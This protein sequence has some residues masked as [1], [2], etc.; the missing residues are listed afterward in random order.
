[1]RVV[2]H[3]GARRRYL[4]GA[5]ILTAWCATI[6][7]A[8]TIA[9]VV[10]DVHGNPLEG[11]QIKMTC[12]QVPEQ[13]AQMISDKDGAYRFI[14]LRPG[15]CDL[16]AERSGFRVSTPTVIT[17][18]SAS[19]SVVS[20]FTLS[21][22][23]Q[24]ENPTASQPKLKF[25]AAGIRGLI[26]PG[27]YSAAANAAAA[28]GVISGIA[29]IRR[30]ENA[31][32]SLV[33]KNLPCSLAP[34]L[35]EAV[36]EDPQ[37]ADANR[38]LGEFYLVHGSA[39]Q[40]IPYL[41]R[42]RQIDVDDSRTIR[43]L[44]E[45]LVTSGQF[46][47]AYEMLS[48]LPESQKDSNYHQ[49]L[50]RAEEGLGQYPQAAEEYRIATERDPNEENSF[51]IGYELILAGQPNAAAK[52]FNA[53]LARHPSS[54]TLLIGA[55]A[56]E[57][58]EGRGSEAVKLFL[59]AADLNP[60]DPRPYSFL[61]GVLAISGEQDEEVRT[62]LKRHL[63]FSSTDAEAYY[64]YALGLLHG[65]AKDGVIDNDRVVSLLKQAV[66]FN[67]TLTKAHFEL[68][69][70]YAHREDY[71]NA[72]REFE[73]AVRLAPDMKEAH[74]RLASAYKKIGRPEAAEREMKLFREARDSSKIVNGESGISIEQFISVVDRSGH[75]TTSETQCGQ[76]SIE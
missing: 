40:A 76:S 57:F 41:K 4:A 8:A 52:A 5:W 15:K 53:G 19:A 42:A 65:S 27:G 31:P 35:T 29:D 68:G 54:I 1:M 23:S 43:D 58:L 18:S 73:V 44:S 66:V 36:T 7:E 48:L 74:Y 49:H 25:E 45:A 26:D 12:E 13:T 51:G 11:A 46:D 75:A 59:Q 3:A 69:I 9:G 14:E 39:N 2:L 61:A 34:E 62:A 16:S 6:A 20:D 60:S 64:L 24:R 32:D 67:P 30:T 22:V 21:E 56:S 28:S 10:R 55:G 33:S 47:A 70:L 17:I 72:A 63:E 71:D 38:R 37:N 50:A